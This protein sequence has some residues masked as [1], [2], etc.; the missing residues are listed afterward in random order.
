MDDADGTRLRSGEDLSELAPIL[1]ETAPEAVLLNCSTPEAIR[2]GLRTLGEF[3]LPFGAYANGFERIE[4]Y[5]LKADSAVEDLQARKDLGPSE[6]ADHVDGWIA[7]GASIVGGC[8]EVGPDH[9][10]EISRRRN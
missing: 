2:Q 3:G 5:F 10:A 9:I 8:C 4:A 1:A 7:Q 6:Y